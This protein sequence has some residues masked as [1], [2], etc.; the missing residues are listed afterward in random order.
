MGRVAPAI[1]LALAVLIIGIGT[2]LL[3]PLGATGWIFALVFAG[4]LYLL[5]VVLTRA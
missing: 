3:A 2:L 1:W 5:S 4:Y